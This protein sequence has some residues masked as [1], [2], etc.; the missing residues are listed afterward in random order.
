MSLTSLIGT[1][2]AG[3]GLFA[4]LPAVSGDVDLSARAPEPHATVL[5][6]AMHEHGPLI[7]LDLKLTWEVDDDTYAPTRG[8]HGG[9][10]LGCADD[11]FAANAAIAAGDVEA[12]SVPLSGHTNHRLLTVHPTAFADR[13]FAS[14]ACAYDIS[15]P[16]RPALVLS[17]VFAIQAEPAP[18][19]LHL[20]LAPA[21][22]VALAAAAPSAAED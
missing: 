2:A 11:A 21:P 3:A 18:T 6:E 8:V 4:H 7:R 10:P 15:F 20:R 19:A 5:L 13:P 22:I 17:G 12:I 14:V 16:G 9:A 1:L